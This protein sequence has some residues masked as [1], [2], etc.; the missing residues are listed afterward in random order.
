MQMGVLSVNSQMG[1]VNLKM[2]QI[3]RKVGTYTWTPTRIHYPTRLRPG[4]YQKKCTVL[5]V[6]IYCSHLQITIVAVISLF[7]FLCNINL[8]HNTLKTP[9]THTSNYPPL[10]AVICCI[11]KCRLLFSVKYQCVSHIELVWLVK[12]MVRLIDYNGP[13]LQA[14]RIIY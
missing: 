8:S 7:C 13:L 1:Q 11:F 12:D 6:H 5:S 9:S 4:N 2:G 14:I 10:L 3:Y